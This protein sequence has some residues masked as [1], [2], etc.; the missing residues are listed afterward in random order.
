[1]S[2]GDEREVISEPTDGGRLLR[3]EGTGHAT[4]G[5]PV[6]SGIGTVTPR[7][8]YV[9]Q[10]DEPSDLWRICHG[11]SRKPQVQVLSPEGEVVLA[12]V[13]HLDNDCLT[14]SF[15]SPYSGSA[16]LG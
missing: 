14:I 13:R 3:I 8:S 2:L 9:H 5:P 6:V 15:A 11:F 1:M 4:I 16:V 12:D 7:E 10:Q